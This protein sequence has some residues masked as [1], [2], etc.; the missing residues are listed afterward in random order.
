MILK[1]D[2]RRLVSVNVTGHPTA[3]WVAR[4]IIDAFPWDAAPKYM[5]RDRD[6]I[7]GNAVGTTVSMAEWIR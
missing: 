3:E 6:A 7:Y 5:I 2:R 1:H 4:Q